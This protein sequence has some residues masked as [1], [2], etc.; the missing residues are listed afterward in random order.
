MSTTDRVLRDTAQAIEHIEGICFKTGPPTWIGTE[1]EW[2]THRAGDPAAHLRPAELSAA[3]GGHAP[4]S[5]G[6]PAPRPLPGGGTVTV[7]PGGQVEISSA[8]AESLTALHAAVTADH[9]TLTGLLARGGIELGE[10]G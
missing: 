1:L 7:E 9:A 6:N 5:L 8:P 4:A 10:R 3:L 2:T